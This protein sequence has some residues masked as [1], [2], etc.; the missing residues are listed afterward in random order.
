MTYDEEAFLAAI[1][2]KPEDEAPHKV[3]AD[4]LDEHD[5][6]EEADWH[7]V[8]TGADRQR[9][10]EWLAH[11][12]SGHFEPYAGDREMDLDDM[13]EAGREWLRSGDYRVQQGG[14]SIQDEMYSESGRREWWKNWA[15]ATGIFVPESVADDGYVFSCT[16]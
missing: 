8:W 2:E 4:W 3:F 5:R 6:P 7:R 15:L 13:I 10:R 16:C 9:A 11:F 1:A 14:E 12:A